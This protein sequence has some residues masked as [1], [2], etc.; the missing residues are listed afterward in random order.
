MSVGLTG[1]DVCRGGKAGIP[2]ALLSVGLVL[3]E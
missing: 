2:K 1:S 3:T